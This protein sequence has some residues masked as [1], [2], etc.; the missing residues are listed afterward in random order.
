[1]E[2][3]E[4]L[5]PWE[6][7]RLHH[8]GLAVENITLALAILLSVGFIGAWLCQ[9]IRLPSVTGYICAGLL[10]G[11]SG[12]NVISANAV[13]PQL[14][15]FIQI[16]LMLIS[17]GIGEHMEISRL[18]S[19]AKSVALI[20][21]SEAIGAFLMV[22][23]GC[24][25]IIK[26][27]GLTDNL[28]D[29]LI[30][31]LLL[32][33]VSIATAPAT[34]MH[35]IREIKATGPMTTSLLAVVAVDN[36]LAIMIFGISLA[37]AGHLVSAGQGGIAATISASFMEIIGSLLLGIITALLLD[38]INNRLRQKGEMLTAGLALLLLCGEAARLLNMSPL[39]AGMAAGFTIINREHRD[40]RLFRTFNAFEPPIYV[41]FFTLA[42][43]HL[44]LSALTTAGWLGLAYFLCRTVGKIGGAGI[45]ALLSSSP[46]AVKRYLGLALTPQAGVAIGL[47]FLINNDPTVHSFADIITPVVLAGIFM[48]EIMGPI[49]V[50]LAIKM[51]GEIPDTPTTQ[52]PKAQDF[53]PT[54]TIPQGVPLPPWTWQKLPTLYRTDRVI[55]FGASH[56]ATGAALARMATIFANFQQA[57]PM[58]AHIIPTE[59]YDRKRKENDDALL[60]VMK[61]EIHTMGSE[62]YTMTKRNDDIA[63]GILEVARQSHTKG[64]VLGHSAMN[65]TAFQKI[66]GQI[67]AESP[68]PTMIIKFSGIFHTERILVP[69]FHPQ[70][71]ETIKTSLRAIAAVGQHKITL[72]RLMSSSDP[73]QEV[74]KAQEQLHHWAIN[75]DLSAHT[76]SRSLATD[77]RKETILT[78]AERHDLLIMAAPPKKAFPQRFIFGSLHD[79]IAQECDKTL[80]TI[81]PPCNDI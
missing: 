78:E 25:V 77:T 67:V 61:A 56:L 66:I 49:F 20:G 65:P 48:S 76:I 75:A 11:P 47:I 4:P 53:P 36:G 79:T 31:A 1:M 27:T 30:L 17:F 3:S 55:V 64:I 42:G 23:V 13:G 22:S 28:L 81:Y 50:K 51:A 12:F 10:L 40:I 35:V 44:N 41:L 39:L 73:M 34:T 16:A 71:L 29:E 54:S 19:S 7:L 2:N 46:L 80:I 5:G 37:V 69:F 15:H 33:S 63:Q 26:L 38:F 59:K 32:G 68:C 21:L 14:E 6:L 9:L 62:L 57:Y 52:T 8:Q 74:A 72:L 18:R 58:A 43:T 24:F 60:D 70:A 45:G